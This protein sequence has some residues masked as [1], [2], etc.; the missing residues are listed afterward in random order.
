MARREFHFREGSVNKFWTIDAEG[1]S[2]TVQFGRIGTAGQTQTKEFNSEAEAEKACAKLIA[3]KLKKGYQEVGSGTSGPTTPATP[4]IGGPALAGISAGDAEQ[5]LPLIIKHGLGAAEQL[6]LANAAVCCR[7]I[8]GE[9]EVPGTRAPRPPLTSR[10]KRSR[11][12][13]TPK[14]AEVGNSRYGGLP[15]V[16]PSFSWPRS[17]HCYFNFLMQVNLAELPPLRENPLPG[18]GL[19]YFFVG[20]DRSHTDVDCR[21]VLHDGPTEVLTRAAP[22]PRTETHEFYYDSVAHRLSCGPGIDLPP[23]GS[24]VFHQI[25]E[26][27]GF[28]NREEAA[29]KY[30]GLVEEVRHLG[31]GWGVGQL[32]GY[33]SEIDWGYGGYGDMRE[34][35]SLV[36]A[37][38]GNRIGD[39]DYR[40]EHR[41]ELR[42]GAQDWR[43]LWRISSDFDVGVCIND[44]GE[45]F[46]LVREAD[47]ARLVFSRVYVEIQAG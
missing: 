29:E 33:P 6:L 44:A 22:P 11:A 36:S 25:A 31:A 35:A 10:S 16:P 15:D 34:H 21:I 47:L 2:F 5:L 46:A 42:K 43:L 26:Q 17:E 41:A 9:P 19:L 32:L 39:L 37:G 27:A 7:L 4:I 13:K 18:R 30:R 45:M 23:C 38:L 14:Y 20:Y 8:R 1:K 3:E 24:E 12:E 28:P 40:R